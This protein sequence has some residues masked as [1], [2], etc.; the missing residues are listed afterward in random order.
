MGYKAE[1]GA[2]SRREV[3]FYLNLVG[4]KVVNFDAISFA[5]STFYLNLV[6]YKVLVSSEDVKLLYRFI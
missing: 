2:Y 6:G 1:V 3:E 5:A 4:Y